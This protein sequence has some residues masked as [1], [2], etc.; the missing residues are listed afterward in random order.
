V[1]VTNPDH[2][3]TTLASGFVYAVRGNANNDG[4]GLVSGTDL[5]FLMNFLYAA[6][7]SPI[8]LCSGDANSNGAIQGSDLTYLMNFLYASG[9]APGN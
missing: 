7:P 8:S 4:S 2:Q 5:T 1:V 6:G 9:P 3:S